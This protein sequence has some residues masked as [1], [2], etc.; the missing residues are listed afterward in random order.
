MALGLLG[1]VSG[2]L[3]LISVYGMA[4]HDFRSGSYRVLFSRPVSVPVYYL[5][6]FLC[7]L[8]AFWL[9]LGLAMFAFLLAEVDAWSPPVLLD[10]T[11]QFLLLGSVI[12]AFSRV[13]RLGW[14]VGY[15]FFVLGTPLRDGYPVGESWFGTLCNVV[16]PPSQLLQPAG[17]GASREISALLPSA[18]PEW[19]D[20]AWVGGY[21]LAAVAVCLILLRVVPMVWAR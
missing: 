21:S 17:R 8:L 13:T 2:F 5:A 11:F 16:L 20:M 9:V 19:W 1:S 7:A 6:S 14:I 18:G 15:M 4:G 12:F 3:T 10:L